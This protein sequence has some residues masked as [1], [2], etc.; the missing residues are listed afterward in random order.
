M[1]TKAIRRD[2]TKVIIQNVR[3][4]YAQLFEPRGFDGQEPKYSTALII[5]KADTETIKVIKEGIKAA[6]ALGV[7][8]F[9]SKFNTGMKQPLRDGD[10]DRAGDEVYIDSYFLNANSKRAPQVVATYKGA[11]GKPVP[12]GPEE[13]YS[14]CYANVSIN[15]YPYQVTAN[16]GVAAGLG[17]IQKAADG[18]PLAGAPNAEDDFDFEDSSVDLDDDLFA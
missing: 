3:L 10:V 18:E 16:K 17:N 9:G 7:E 2:D 14:G 5:P 15:F 12:L 13:V 6:A 1:K 4:S 8:K 11:D